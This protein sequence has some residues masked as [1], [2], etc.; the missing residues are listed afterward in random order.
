MEIFIK[1]HESMQKIHW[2]NSLPT[3]YKD[4]IVDQILDHGVKLNQDSNYKIV[5]DILN[6]KQKGNNKR[7]EKWDQYQAGV[8]REASPDAAE[9]TADRRAAE[10]A[11]NECF[12]KF[13]G[14][15]QNKK[16]L[17]QELM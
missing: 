17:L 8:G 2:L 15:L 11:Q 7:P 6:T 12:G 5:V 4:E 9:M 3:K 13:E 1:K 16:Q 14:D 10:D